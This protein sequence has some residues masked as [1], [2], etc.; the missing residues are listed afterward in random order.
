MIFAP[1][2][3]PEKRRGWLVR[4][5]K[6]TGLG[7]AALLVPLLALA[8]YV[9]T[10]YQVPPPQLYHYAWETAAE[11]IYDPRDLGNW[12]DWEH[13]YDGKLH[14][15]EEAIA[16]ANDALKTVGDPYTYVM[17]PEQVTADSER[18]RGNFIGV[19]LT[20]SVQQDAE[21]KVVTDPSGAPLAQVDAAG[22]VIVQSVMPGAPAQKA[23]LKAGDALVSVDGVDT[24]G[25]PLDAIVKR[26]RN[27]GPGTTVTF[28]VKRGGNE[29]PLTI[30][31][32]K[33]KLAAVHTRMLP[34]NIGYLR[35]DDFSQS[36][37]YTQFRRGLEDLKDARALVIDLRGNPGGFVFNA[38][39]ISSFF[40]KEGVVVTIKERV[41]GDPA[42]PVYRT[43]TTYLTPDKLIEEA[44]RSDDPTRVKRKVHDRQPYLADDRPVVFLVN[45]GSAS[46]S[47]MTTGAVR[48][49]G[50]AT[51]VGEKTFGKGVGQATVFMPNG[52]RLHVTSL[53]YY[54][55]NGTWLGNGRAKTP[56]H[57]EQPANGITPDVEVKPDKK[58]FESG[59]TEDNQ[60]RRAIEVV[61]K[62]LG[63]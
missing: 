37:A 32:E 6:H 41:P 3:T 53:R 25:A 2:Y 21:G 20:F 48:D 14:S 51:V 39:N 33:V 60:L 38:I 10:Q 35:L 16:A 7:G 9:L 28:V 17:S 18:A 40:I 63:D 19:G 42:R 26:V 13:K 54:T 29:F 59:S 56:A 34:D 57:G 50:A 24:R 31:R 36:D 45:E 58:Y 47:E 4:A 11:T 27:G 15:D 55:P 49:N 12:S 43:V 23:G 8:L 30:T 22:H 1:R 44:T 46:A 5:I 52:T 61:R 62:Q